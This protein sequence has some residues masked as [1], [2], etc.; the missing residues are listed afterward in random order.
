MPGKKA[1]SEKN[2]V[3]I[4]MAC[5]SETFFKIA[6]DGNWTPNSNEYA[7]LPSGGHAM[8]V[9]GYDDDVNGGS[10]EVMNSWGERWGN[11]GFFWIKYSDFDAFVRYGFEIIPAQELVV[12][13]NGIINFKELSGEDMKAS[14]DSLTGI[15]KMNKPYL[16]GTQFRFYM[17]NNEPAFVYALGSDL[18]NKSFRI[19]PFNDLVSAYL[20]YKSNEVAIPDEDH[21]IFMDKNKGTD[22]L[23]VLYSKYELNIEKILT[24]M[25]KVSGDFKT[26][27]DLVLKDVIINPRQIQYSENIIG[28]KAK[29]GD[30]SVVPIIIEIAHN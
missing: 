18:S 16:S 17:N 20:G 8:A 12:D 9:I 10:F 3:V 4:G 5:C 19:F 2:P 23:C 25:E 22:Y 1:I 28:F 14:F 27:L 13:L 30:K 7:S 26:R 11:K 29:S 15:Y 6:R 24:E 21:C